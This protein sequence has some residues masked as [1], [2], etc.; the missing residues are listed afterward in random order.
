MLVLSRKLSES[1]YIGDD[2]VITVVDIREDKIR[3]G[4]EARREIP[5]HRE[6]VYWAIREEQERERNRGGAA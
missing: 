5:V 2:I 3:L 1:I 4:I 6:E